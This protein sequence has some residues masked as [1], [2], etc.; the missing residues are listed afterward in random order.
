MS[1][2]R[3]FFL[4][5]IQ[6]KDEPVARLMTGSDLDIPWSE[7]DNGLEIIGSEDEE[8]NY[9]SL[10]GDDHNELEEDYVE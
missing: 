8:N 4:E 2:S 6:S 3:L 9:C 7:L 5:T 10:G 1:C